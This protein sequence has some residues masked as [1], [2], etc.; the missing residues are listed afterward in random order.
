MKERGRE[1]GSEGRKGEVK[2]EGRKV[3]ATGMEDS[4]LRK[5]VYEAM[6]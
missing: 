1:E 5:A 4:H 3:E 6:K 2:E